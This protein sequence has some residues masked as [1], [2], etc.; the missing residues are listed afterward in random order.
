MHHMRGLGRLFAIAAIFLLFVGSGE[1]WTADIYTVADVSV[2]ERATDEVAAKTNGLAKAQAAALRTL[3]ERLTQRID[4]ERLPPVTEEMVSRALRDFSVSKERFGGG[5][6]LAELSV[7][8]R[9]EGVRTMLRAAGIPYAEVASRPTLVLPVYRRGGSILLWD[10]PNPWFD[11]WARH[12]SPSGLLPIVIPLR[13][14]GDVS[15]ISPQ[16]ALAGDDARLK[17]I[18]E[19]YKAFSV[20]VAVAL[21][22]SDRVSGQSGASVNLT[23]YQS[24]ASPSR[25]LRQFSV[26]EGVSR[27]ALLDQ[28]VRET[29]SD[30]EEAWKRENL[31]EIDAEQRIRVIVP[32]VR[33][34]DWLS[35]RRKM[36]SVPSVKKIDVAR[37]S[38][39]EAAVNVVFM[40]SPEQLRRALSLKDLD[41]VYSAESDSW[42]VRPRAR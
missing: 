24:G 10:E 27:K 29:I 23:Y 21:V 38:V 33:L 39:R 36:S 13:E 18:A 6:Y 7:R 42:F 32:L 19:R 30:I 15:T 11:A 14:L 22:R 12:P 5:R 31:Q 34:G 35:V 37:L 2:D 26:P 16:Q 25:A 1:A 4:H 28:A 3:F 20:F 40:G 8:F 9:P 17:A 41:M